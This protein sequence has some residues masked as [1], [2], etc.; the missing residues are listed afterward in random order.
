MYFPTIQS[1]KDFL[2]NLKQIEIKISINPHLYQTNPWNQSLFAELSS[3][4]LLTKIG[5]F[6][7]AILSISQIEVPRT[8]IPLK[9][10]NQLFLDY[11]ECYKQF[12]TTSQKR[13]VYFST[14]YTISIIISYCFDKKVGL[15]LELAKNLHLSAIELFEQDTPSSYQKRIERISNFAIN[16]IHIAMVYYPASQLATLSFLFQISR[17]LSV[18]NSH[19]LKDYSGKIQFE[20]PLLELGLTI[21]RIYILKVIINNEEAE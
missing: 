5:I 16:T 15:A 9:L 21:S 7:T 18:I 10:I 6:T 19:V 2:H 4:D 14:L 3:K 13:L 17:G 20:S 1:V 8:S 11:K 12:D